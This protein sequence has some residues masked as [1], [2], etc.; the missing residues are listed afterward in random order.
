MSIKST[1]T[2]LKFANA[3]K[4]AALQAFIDEYRL[5]VER[6]VNALWDLRK[7]PALVPAAITDIIGA[8]TWL[9]ARAVQSA[10]K[11]ASGIVRGTRKKQEKRAAIIRRLHAEGKH[12]AARKLRAIYDAVKMSRPNIKNVNP[13]LDS[14]FVDLD[15]HDRTSFDGWLTLSSLGERGAGVAPIVLPVRKSRHFNALV[16]QGGTMTAGV[17]ISPTEISFTFDMPP[18]PLR[19]TGRTTGVDIG[20]TTTLTTSDGQSVAADPHGHTYQSICATLA[21]RTKDSKGFD[22][23]V[24]HRTNY[25]G[26]S[27]K[28][29]NL[30]GVKTVNI[31]DIKGLRTGKRGSRLMSHWNYAEC[32]DRLTNLLNDRGVHV[33]RV[34]PAYTSQ[35]CSACGWT[36]KANRKGKRFRCDK[37]HFASDSDL[38]ASLNLAL[39]L[40]EITR[41]ARL[42]R[43]NLAGFWWGAARPSPV[44][45]EEPIV[46]RVHEA[47]SVI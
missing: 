16:A 15:F 38:N 41:E 29:L 5:V 44:V 12:R 6:A 39:T 24:A 33:N 30:E 3:S 20:M 23:A 45:G 18:V 35:R 17:R 27:V 26:W 34:D 11:Q 47:E 28:Q 22:R 37:C 13:E 8:D 43:R 14:R 10:A 19:P 21:R 42:Q 32:F 9:S 40:P 1:R 4:L 46:P 2:T 7:V 31:E 25:L 36:R